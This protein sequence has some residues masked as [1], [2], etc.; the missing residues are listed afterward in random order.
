VSVLRWLREGGRSA[1]LLSPRWAGLH[2]GPGAAL[3]WLATAWALNAAIDW[4]WIDGP[5][6]LY[7]PALLQGWLRVV[8]LAGLCW[9]LV[10]RMSG[11]AATRASTV[12]TLLMAQSC[13]LIVGTAVFDWAVSG[14]PWPAPTADPWLLWQLPLIWWAASA[15]ALLWRA[16]AASKRARAWG[17]VAIA[18]VTFASGQWE[19]ARVWYAATDRNERPAPLVLNQALLETQAQLLPAQLQ[20]LAPQRPGVVDVYAL[21]FAPYAD[22][23]VFLRESGMVSEV[24]QQRFGAAGRSLQLVNHR[25][26]ATDL[27]WATPLNLQRAIHGIAESMDREED[28]LF[29]HLTSHGAKDGQLAAA[30]DPLTIEPLTP[31]LLKAALDEAGIRHRIVSVS[32][33]YSGSWIAPLQ[34]EHTLVLTAA[35]AQHTSYGCGT[36]SELTFFGRALYDELL[37]RETLDFETAHAKARE[38]IARREKE[39]GKDDG[40]S[41]PQIAMGGAMRAKL[42]TLA[43]P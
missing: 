22:E 6:T 34:G 5:A 42:R 13:V 11:A 23:D 36:R 24:M 40:Y 27:A 8:L 32:A 43:W 26:T 1:V 35:D 39:A 3:F 33:C 25:S 28:V 9:A 20:T 19:T 21:T 37:R 12:F 14:R 38:V 10:E 2:G 31:A 30:F 18:A 15:S 16:S 17:A 4:W 29:I 41:N 7:A